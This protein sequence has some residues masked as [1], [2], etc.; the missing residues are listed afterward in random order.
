MGSSSGWIVVLVGEKGGWVIIGTKGEKL[1]CK[2]DVFA[3]TYEPVE[4]E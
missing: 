4:E 2:P 1:V 3:K